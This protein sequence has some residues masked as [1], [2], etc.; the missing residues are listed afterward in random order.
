MAII[1]FKKEKFEE[2][3]FE[4]VLICKTIFDTYVFDFVYHAAYDWLE[5]YSCSSKKYNPEKKKYTM[6]QIMTFR[7]KYGNHVKKKIQKHLIKNYR[8]TRRE[9]TGLYFPRK[10]KHSSLLSHA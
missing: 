10:G 1:Q 5:L 3:Y 6:L 9:G 8:C 4:G 2:G 7:K